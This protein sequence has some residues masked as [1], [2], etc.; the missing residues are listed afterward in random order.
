MSLSG[1]HKMNK[2]EPR[3]LKALDPVGVLPSVDLGLARA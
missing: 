2:R 1:K 3:F